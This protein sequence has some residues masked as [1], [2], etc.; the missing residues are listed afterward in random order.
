VELNRPVKALKLAIGLCLLPLCVAA[1]RGVALLVQSIQP[2]ASAQVPAAAWWL[3]GGF[4]LWLFLFFVTPRPVRTYVLAHEL[5]HAL[6]GW[7][8]GA[9]VSRLR[10]SAKG[11]SVRVSKNNFL[12]SLAPYFFPL[13]TV[14]A[15][16]AYY[17]LS[18]FLDL[19]AYE[20]FW[21]AVVGFTWCFHLTFTVTTLMQHQPDIR[22]NGRLFSYA[23]IWLMNVL[24][25]G[26]WIV[27]VASP[28]LQDLADILVRQSTAAWAGCWSGGRWLAS[29]TRRIFQSLEK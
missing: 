1:T 7:I 18:V 21:L 3:V 25:I 29:E 13:Y 27:M 17:L 2:S 4:L 9:R 11:G 5:T 16:A 12:I 20:P 6:W 14:L 26:L 28:T 15:I 8:M 23:L 19:R 10:V 24:G 22:Q